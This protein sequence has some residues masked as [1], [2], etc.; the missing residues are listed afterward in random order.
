MLA[1]SYNGKISRNNDKLSKENKHTTTK[2]NSN[3][4]GVLEY[5]HNCDK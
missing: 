5:K 4:N 1:L 2:P 3:K